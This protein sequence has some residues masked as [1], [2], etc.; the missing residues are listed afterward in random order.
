MAVKQEYIDLLVCIPGFTV[1]L[2]GAIE[3][4]DGEKALLIDLHRKK[5]KYKCSCGKK[6]DTYYDSRER[7]VR[8]LRFGPYRQSF[9]VFRQ[10]R[11][12]CPDCGVV[13]EILPWVGPKV[14]YTKRLGALVALSCQEI[15]S[16]SAV[17]KEYGLHWSTV[18]EIHKAAL[19]KELPEPRNTSPRVIGVDE[20]AV[21][22]RHKYGTVVVDFADKSVPYVGKD[23]TKTSLSNY[24]RALG[25]RKCR[26][27]QAVAMDM[28]RP[29]EE[30]VRENCPEAQIVYDPFHIISAYGRDV[31]DKVRT[32][33]VAKAAE[34]DKKVIKG[35]RYLLLKNKSSLDPSR[36]EP[37]KLADLLQQNESINTVYVLKDDLKC[38]WGHKSKS[39][40]NSWFRDWY[41]RAKESGIALLDRF[42]DKLKSHLPGILAYCDYPITTGI[43]EGINNKIKVIK[44]VS[45]GYRDMEYF[46]LRIRGAFH[47]KL[48]HSAP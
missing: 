6:F 21:R 26:K 45:F 35:S 12:D 8:D 37:A 29:Y 32:Q 2:V 7:C 39:K 33:E 5:C 46:F 22:R 44:R 11:I 19:K 25:E 40:A 42:A 3:T 4:G 41:K 31:V 47:R 20:F 16:I 15:R 24:F 28:W 18:K 9:L 23:R 17:A 34:E 14:G 10:V 27:I 43:I 36:N 38:L 48:F 1:G 13:T 30:A